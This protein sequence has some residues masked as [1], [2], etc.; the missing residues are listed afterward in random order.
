[1]K[2]FFSMMVA[3]ATL[4]SF[5]ACEDNDPV[6][7]QPVQKEQLAAP[8]LT[9][10]DVTA[11]GFTV[12]WEAVANAANYT[13]IIDGGNSQTITETSVIFTDLIAG[14]HTVGVKAMA[15][16]NTNYSDS[17][18]ATIKQSVEGS[19]DWFSQEVYTRNNPEEGVYTNNMIFIKWTGSNIKSIKYAALDGTLS[20]GASDD[21]VIANMSFADGSWIETINTDGFVELQLQVGP[22]TKVEVVALATDNN[23][24]TILERDMITTDPAFATIEDYLGTFTATFT[25]QCVWSAN[26][27]NQVAPAIEECDAYTRTLTIDLFDP[28]NYP[29]YVSIYGF[30]AMADDVLAIGF[31]DAAGFLYIMNYQPI[32]D[33]GEDGYT[34]TWL[35]VA[36]GGLVGTQIGYTIT[37]DGKGGFSAVGA[38]STFND[39]TPFKIEAMEVFALNESTG[40]VG[41]YVNE[42][43][44]THNAGDFTMVKSEP[45]TAST[46]AYSS[47]EFNRSSY[48]VNAPIYL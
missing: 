2:K 48:V 47:F 11:T 45:A 33:V 13:V 37:P 39:G 29:G 16:A 31:V 44:F 27:Q 20:E 18:M 30:S 19:T 10:S 5:T 38:T 21:D 15:A 40:G 3:M 25:K 26:T 4:V 17:T 28:T 9:V 41:F 42:F 24:Q 36:D 14:E 7:P 32:G 6:E 8:V 1:M 35:G 34:P 23:G 12:S 46:R 22:D 43:P